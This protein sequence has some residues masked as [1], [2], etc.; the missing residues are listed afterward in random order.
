[1]LITIGSTAPP[2][3]NS[4]LIGTPQFSLGQRGGKHLAGPT[5]LTA[6][7]CSLLRGWIAD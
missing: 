6:R 1:M 5:V 7:A 2:R 4:A 3:V